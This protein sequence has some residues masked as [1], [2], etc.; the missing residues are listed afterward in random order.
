VAYQKGNVQIRA[1][2]TA[3][4]AIKQPLAFA[5]LLGMATA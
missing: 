3:D 4:I 2:A 1:M 5:A